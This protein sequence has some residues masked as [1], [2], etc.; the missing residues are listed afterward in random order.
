MADKFT[1]CDDDWSLYNGGIK[2]VVT[3]KMTYVGLKCLKTIGILSRS[4]KKIFNPL[5]NTNNIS[6]KNGQFKLNKDMCPLQFCT[7]FHYI[8]SGL[9]FMC[10]KFG[11]KM[12]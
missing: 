7:D 9:K 1:S 12:K 5:C 11:I 8:W 2:I 6:N 10:G 4:S 3:T